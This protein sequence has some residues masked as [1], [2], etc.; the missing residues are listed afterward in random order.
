MLESVPSECAH[1]TRYGA[2]GRIRT[3]ALLTTVP[4]RAVL[5]ANSIHARDLHTATKNV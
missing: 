3:K 1:Y 5:V 2:I 4:G